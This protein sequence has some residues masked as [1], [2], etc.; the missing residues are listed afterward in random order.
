ML[1]FVL[2]SLL[3]KRQ[4][5]EKSRRTWKVWLFDVSKQLIGQALVHASNLLVSLDRRKRSL[6][7]VGFVQI[8]DLSC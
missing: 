8:A 3:V 4:F 2:T 7:F 5:F 1:I 6:V